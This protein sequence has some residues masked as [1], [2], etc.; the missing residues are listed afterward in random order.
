MQ[1]SPALRQALRLLDTAPERLRR[2]VTPPAPHDLLRGNLRGGGIFHPIPVVQ[3]CLAGPMR[4]RTRNQ[5]FD[6]GPGDAIAIPA[7]TWHGYPETHPQQLLVGFGWLG[8]RSDLWMDGPGFNLWASM[9]HEPMRG[10]IRRAA[11]AAN[12]AERLAMVRDLLTAV[13]AEDLDGLR[14]V[15]A[16]IERMLE[17]VLRRLHLGPTAADLVHASGLG[18]SQAYSLFT[19]FYGLSPR[20][21]L[22]LRRLELAKALLSAG[23]GVSETAA[24]CGWRNRETFSRRWSRQHGC[25]PRAS[26]LPPGR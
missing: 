21:A 2:V 1:F 20:R 19:S 3:V 16:P 26:R 8:S 7:A 23:H 6:L 9:P 17:V 13:A 24:A 11:T 10:L 25:P 14:S 22:E 4:V 15:P 5:R 18:R 12:E